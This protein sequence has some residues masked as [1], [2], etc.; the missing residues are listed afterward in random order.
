MRCSVNERRTEML[1]AAGRIRRSLVA[2]VLT[3]LAACSSWDDGP[4]GYRPPHANVSAGAV[5]SNDAYD[6]EAHAAALRLQNNE[7]RR[8]QTPLAPQ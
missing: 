5:H 3:S 6:D 1:L 7:A 2:V 8:R 4:F